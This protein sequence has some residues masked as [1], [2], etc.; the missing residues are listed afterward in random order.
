VKCGELR[1]LLINSWSYPVARLVRSAVRQPSDNLDAQHDPA[2]DLPRLHH[3]A[4]LS[5]VGE[6]H[7]FRHADTQS[8]AAIGRIFA[9]AGQPVGSAAMISRYGGSRCSD[10][11][12]GSEKASAASSTSLSAAV[13]RPSCWCRC[14]C[15]DATLKISMKRSG[16]SPSR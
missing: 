7:H 16:R 11:A 1:P 10:R 13:K 15:H 9:E 14:S 3:A 8:N 4:R 5:G 6:R 2:L 12:G